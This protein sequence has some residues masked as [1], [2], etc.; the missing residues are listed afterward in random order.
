MVSCPHDTDAFT[1]VKTILR[2]GS[3]FLLM[4]FIRT[5]DMLVFKPPQVRSGE[6]TLSLVLLHTETMRRH[7]LIVIVTFLLTKGT[8]VPSLSCPPFFDVFVP[9]LPC[10]YWVNFYLPPHSITTQIGVD[11]FHH[12]CLLQ[13]CLH[14]ELVNEEALFFLLHPMS[15]L[16]GSIFEPKD[17]E[18]LFMEGL[19]A[20]GKAL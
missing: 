12:P 15:L 20:E 1:L 11:A 8:G 4:T 19:L 14:I 2:K 10:L 13:S 6:D 7:A 16:F 9:L 18:L 17:S 3:I 5:G